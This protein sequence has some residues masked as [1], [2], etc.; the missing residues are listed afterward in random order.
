MKKSLSILIAIILGILCYKLHRLV[1]LTP[2]VLMLMLFFPSLK[3]KFEIKKKK[4]VYLLFTILSIWMFGL[5]LYK[6][7]VF[8][9]GDGDVSKSALIVLTSPIA[10]AAALMAE[11]M[12]GD[13]LFVLLLSVLTNILNVFAWPFL[14]ESLYGQ[15]IE[16]TQ[17]LVR[18]LAIVLIPFILARL[19]D[20]FTK[21]AK[22]L[23]KY[24]YISF[25]AWMFGIF[26]NIAF[27]SN[28]VINQKP[29]LLELWKILLI[30]PVICILNLVFGTFLGKI[31]DLKKE[32]SQSFVQR[33]TFI[34]VWLSNTFFNPLIAMGPIFYI[35]CQNIY[36]TVQI[37]LAGDGKKPRS[38]PKNRCF[39]SGP[40]SKRPNWNEKILKNAPV[41]RSHRS[42]YCLDII[43]DVLKKSREILDIPNDYKMGIIG[44]SD[45]G[46]FECAVWNLLG[47]R[48]VDVVYFEE[49][50]RHWRNDIIDQLK[51]ND[52]REFRA[53]FGKIPDISNLDFNR[54]VVF[55][56]N[57]TTSGVCFHNLNFIP[58]DRSGLVF[59]DATSA[60]FSIPIDFSKIDILTYS[61]QKSLGGEAQHG[62]LVLSPRAI[63]RLEKFNP[64]RPIPRLFQIKKNGKII[65]DVFNGS[66]IN[67]PSMLC[68]YD[69]LDSLNWCKKYG[70]IEK[71]YKIVNDNY[72][73]L[74]SFID[75]KSWIKNLCEE[76]KFQSKTS[77]CFTINSEEFNKLDDLNKKQKIN[78]IYQ[79]IS[80]EKVG[81]DFVNHK[82]APPSFRI[83][84]G[85]TV[86][87][88][89]IE[90][91]CNWIEYGYG[92]IKF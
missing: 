31:L 84:C 41:G 21:Y 54:D 33:N 23:S 14:F 51:I 70:G 4:L 44:G 81:F 79:F 15:D 11:I 29:N 59:C 2:Y 5:I 9:F 17:M 19:I 27:S 13:I 67:T 37:Y 53:E 90:I 91:L 22:Q 46:A 80:K 75:S 58:N 8:I 43:K 6:I 57:G 61:W 63:E 20:K 16:M 77:V 25:Y 18:L 82:A 56:L 71:M 68:I 60:V 12:G 69:A 73:T 48:G 88:K 36:N 24:S 10:T 62:I 1:A 28:Y 78:E 74:S 87:K 66:T 7:S 64:E 3:V 76:R 86:N 26:I 89:D 55:T 50:G 83:W 38:K 65:E 52:T 45:T 35:I 72:L 47:E 49:F 42:T 32:I 34:A 39:G 30:I 92:Q 85:P 40:C